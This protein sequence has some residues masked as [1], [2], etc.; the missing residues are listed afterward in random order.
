M[1]STNAKAKIAKENNSDFK[2]GF[3]DVPFIN[4]ANTIPAPIAAPAKPTV[5]K[6]DPIILAANNILF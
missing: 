2:L 5:H 1:D 4:E 6:P 3:L